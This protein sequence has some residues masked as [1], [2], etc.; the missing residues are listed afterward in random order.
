MTIP[1][2]M[3]VTFIILLAV[4]SMWPELTLALGTLH[5][6]SYRIMGMPINAVPL[7]AGPNL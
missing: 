4:P 7:W 1:K 6:V 5:G 3:K 2:S